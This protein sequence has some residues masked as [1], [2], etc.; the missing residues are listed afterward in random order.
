MQLHKSTI[1]GSVRVL[2]TNRK[3]PTEKNA[4]ILSN[5]IIY[6]HIKIKISYN[7]ILN[8]TYYYH[9]FYNAATSLP[10]GMTLSFSVI[11]RSAGVVGSL[12]S[13]SFSVIGSASIGLSVLFSFGG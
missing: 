11:S 5:L 7:K 4:I 9:D 12:R 1:K 10:C 6:S 8:I 2:N 13:S 3:M